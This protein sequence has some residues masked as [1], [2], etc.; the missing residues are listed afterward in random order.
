[1]SE[2]NNNSVRV[3]YE[4]SVNG[5]FTE[6]LTY[7]GE[8]YKLFE[9]SINDLILAISQLFILEF[10]DS[11]SLAIDN[12]KITIDLHKNGVRVFSN[13]HSAFHCQKDIFTVLRELRHI[14]YLTV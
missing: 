6:S 12:N 1:M 8:D 11:G 14:Q 10:T 7:S 2:E 3:K 5:I 13:I 9:I 4:F